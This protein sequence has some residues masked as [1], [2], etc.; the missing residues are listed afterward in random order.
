MLI[1]RYRKEEEELLLVVSRQ[2]QR[3]D[4]HHHHDDE[5]P[6]GPAIAA[7]RES[8]FAGRSTAARAAWHS[9]TTQKET[10]DSGSRQVEDSES[11]DR[12]RN[13]HDDDNGNTN[14]EHRIDEE[15]LCALLLPS[16]RYDSSSR[17]S[18]QRSAAMQS[19]DDWQHGPAPVDGRLLQ[20]QAH[21]ARFEVAT[22][23][24]A[25]KTDR[26]VSY[27]FGIRFLD[28]ENLKVELVIDFVKKQQ[29]P[30]PHA[31]QIEEADD[32]DHSTGE[33]DDDDAREIPRRRRPSSRQIASVRFRISQR[34]I[35]QE[36]HRDG[37]LQND[38]LVE[39]WHVATVLSRV[40]SYLE[41][42][43][44]RRA[45]LSRFPFVTAVQNES[46]S[47][48][49]RIPL[50]KKESHANAVYSSLRRENN[51]KWLHI[52]WGW[53][54][55]VGWD[56]LAM[57]PPL[58]EGLGA[59]SYGLETLI[60]LTGSCEDAIVTVLNLPPTVDES[61]RKPPA[62]RRRDKPAAART[63]RSESEAEREGL[64]AYELERLVRVRRNE[65]R[66]VDLGLVAPNASDSP[67]SRK[68]REA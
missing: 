36:L 31:R 20:L 17:P 9:E 32:D 41:F 54:W 52:E 60:E 27:R 6:T 62:K 3:R 23:E 57:A 67:T 8:S 55:N 46:S 22:V 24:F 66:M 44:K 34:W 56:Q 58:L 37:F 13:L 50:L 33:G 5:G 51:V 61:S 29:R 15:E 18:L 7:A 28:D 47:V 59:H 40:A 25:S 49:L 38:I 2:P 63:E 11:S 14:P 68:R 48:L 39:S 4:N 12:H 65:Q 19:S 35:Q 42:D 10:A 43:A 26:T 30:L 45:F 1:E 21:L 64:S 16:H 53:G